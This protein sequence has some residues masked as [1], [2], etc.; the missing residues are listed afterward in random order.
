VGQRDDSKK[1]TPREYRRFLKDKQHKKYK[2]MIQEYY[3][4][5]DAIG[6]LGWITLEQ[7]RRNG[8]KK[9]YVLQDHAM[10]SNIKHRLNRLLNKFNNTAYCMKKDFKHTKNSFF[11]A[12]KK[13]DPILIKTESY[14]ISNQDFY[15]G[16]AFDDF[17]A[18][19]RKYLYIETKYNH[20]NR[21]YYE[22]GIKSTIVSQYFQEKIALNWITR[23]REIDPVLESKIDKLMDWLY[24]NNI[25]EKVG[26]NRTR[27]WDRVDKD[28]Y[29][30]RKYEELD[31]Y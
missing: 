3:N 17:D 1:N 16:K 9:Y 19:L 15:D 25:W 2:R 13:G 11:Y 10:H 21:V 8:Y 5:M 12:F 23:V 27:A 31:E 22:V 29:I 14:R 30:K 4:L 7:P 6:N 24:N 20:R 18:D 26:R 28:Y